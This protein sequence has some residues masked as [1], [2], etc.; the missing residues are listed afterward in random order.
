[1]EQNEGHRDNRR[2]RDRDINVLL[3]I[4]RLQHLVADGTFSEKAI[5]RFYSYE[6]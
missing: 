4:K 6:F 3:P 1:L 5:E 2:L